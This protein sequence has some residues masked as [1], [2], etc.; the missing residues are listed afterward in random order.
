MDPMMKVINA[1][2]DLVSALQELKQQATD[3]FLNTFEE[4]YNPEKDEHKEETSTDPSDTPSDN[5]SNEPSIVIPTIP[6]DTPTDGK[7][8]YEG[9]EKYLEDVKGTTVA[10]PEGLG[11]IHTYMGWQCITAKS[12]NQYK[13]REAAGMNFDEEGFAKIGDRYVVATTT[14]F[15]KVGDF[16]DFY[17]E[18]GTVIKCVIG[19]IKSQGDAGCTKWGHNNGRCVVEFVVDKSKWYGNSMHA[20]PGT[21]S[22]HPEWNQNIDKIVNKGNFF[23][24]ITTDAAKFDKT[25]TT[26]EQVTDDFVKVATSN[27]ISEKFEVSGTTSEAYSS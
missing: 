3:G 4:I 18:D 26:V 21:S 5:P 20:N 15:G 8:N 6:G 14:T 9:I 17:Q 13:L 12:S 7:Y 25:Y 11:S 27:A 16:I 19:D 1:L 24:L 10:L 22:C 2:S 23:E